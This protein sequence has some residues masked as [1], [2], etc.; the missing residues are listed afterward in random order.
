MAKN[1]MAILL[2]IA[3]LSA[4]GQS[5]IFISVGAAASFG[6][7]T[8]TF[9]ASHQTTSA[10][11]AEYEKKII[12]TMSVL[13]GVSWYNLGYQYDGN[14]FASNSSTFKANYLAV[15]VMARWNM[16]NKNMFYLDFGMITSWMAQAHLTEGYT[17]FG[18]PQKADGDIAAYSNRLLLGAKFQETVLLNR[19]T[20]SVY[21]MVTFKGQNTVRN[22]PEHW[23]LNQQQSPYL[24]SN[25]Y[26]DYTLLGFRVGVR[27]K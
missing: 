9:F 2:I 24:Q 5:R 10:V 6:G 15:P 4:T 26:S 22:L 23:P 25:G 14:G 1:L 20:L 21:F 18:F 8:D 27:I 16:F 13:T 17:R 3:S 7:N 19:F 12:G 11:D